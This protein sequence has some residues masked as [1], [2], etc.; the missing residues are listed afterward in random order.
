MSASQMQIYGSNGI[1]ENLALPLVRSFPNYCFLSSK[2]LKQL[3]EYIG[4][5]CNEQ[6]FDLQRASLSDKNLYFSR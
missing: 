2:F 5:G 4:F 1:M 3:K 6:P